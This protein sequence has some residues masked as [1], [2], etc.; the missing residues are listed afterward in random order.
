MSKRLRIYLLVTIAMNHPAMAAS[1]PTQSFPNRPGTPD[2]SVISNC[3]VYG[4]GGAAVFAEGAHNIIVDGLYVKGTPAAIK[5][6]GAKNLKVS[7]VM[8]HP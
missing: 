3:R 8:H 2:G 5:A 4:S 1:I 6:R 7:G